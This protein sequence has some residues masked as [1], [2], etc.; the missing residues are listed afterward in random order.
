[1]SNKCLK[2]RELGHRSSD[3]YSKKLNFVEAKVGKA[4]MNDVEDGDDEEALELEVDERELLNCIMQKILLALK[5]NDDNQ[6]KKIFRSHGTINDK[7]RNM[8]ID[9]DDSENIVSKALIDVIRLS[10]EKHLASYKIRWIKKEV[11]TRVI[12]VCRD[13]FSIRKIYKSD[14]IFDVVDINACHLLLGK[15]RQFDVNT[16]YR[17]RDDVYE[18]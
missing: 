17:G 3:C 13:H 7:V 15:P 9:S 2:C 14:M 18:F 16:I 11:E 4:E 8:I 6:R 1:M 5:F 12:K 10:T